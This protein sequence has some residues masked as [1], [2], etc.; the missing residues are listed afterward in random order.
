MGLALQDDGG[1]HGRYDPTAGAAPQEPTLAADAPSFINGISGITKCIPQFDGEGDDDESEGELGRRSPSICD[2]IE[3]RRRSPSVGDSSMG[4]LGRINNGITGIIECIRAW[5]FATAEDAAYQFHVALTTAVR[6]AFYTPGVPVVW[7]EGPM[8]PLH[9]WFGGEPPRLQPADDVQGRGGQ[10]KGTGKIATSDGTETI[11]F[12]N[13][14]VQHTEPTG[15]AVYSYAIQDNGV[16]HITEPDGTQIYYF[17]D[18][19]T[20]SRGSCC[21][22]RLRGHLVSGELIA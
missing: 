8:P 14:D 15:A 21:V 12:D 1:G 9:V 19:L 11:F 4:E 20:T 16:T 7:S 22:R 17:P 3:L 18:G 6:K 5:F 10:G 2:S 13:G